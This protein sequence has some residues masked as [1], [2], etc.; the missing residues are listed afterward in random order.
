M[1]SDPDDEPAATVQGTF[2][3]LAVLALPA[4]ALT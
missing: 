4:G 3:A 2:S 1:F